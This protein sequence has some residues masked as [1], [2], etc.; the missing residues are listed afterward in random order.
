MKFWKAGLA[1]SAVLSLAGVGTS[2]NAA[3][4]TYDWTV[5]AFGTSGEVAPGL[6]TITVTSES[7]GQDPITGITGEIGGTTLTGVGAST[8]SNNFLY[9][10]GA[11]TVL[12]TVGFN[13]T[14]A[15]GTGSIFSFQA[16]GSTVSP[17]S[18]NLDGFTGLPSGFVVGNFNIAPVPLPASWT[19][20]L[21]G[22]C[23]LG[24]LATRKKPAGG[25][26]IGFTAA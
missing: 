14:T 23:G 16:Q 22:I 5:S 15:T 25:R 7:N 6:G 10:N 3:S 9:P 11:P 1:V 26:L 21:L 8:G 4:I 24:F 2:A 13:F 17:G 12:D 20:L 19:V 18:V